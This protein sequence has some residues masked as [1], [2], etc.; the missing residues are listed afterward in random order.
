MGRAW[1]K[2]FFTLLLVSVLDTLSAFSEEVA[3]FYRYSSKDGLSCNY[4]HSITQDSHGFL[5]I[6]TEYGLNRFDGVHFRSF[7]AEDYPSLF[8]NQ[9]LTVKTGSDDK[10]LVASNNGLV[11]YYD[12]ENDTFGDLMPEDFN[13]TY[14]KSVTGFCT[15][16]RNRT[17]MTTS[18]GI[19]RFSPEEQKFA[20]V[21]LVTDSTAFTF[22]SKMVVDPFGRFLCG[23]YSGVV[24]IDSMGH[25][26][27][28]YDEL[29]KFNNMIFNLL[30]MD[31]YHYIVSSYV[32]SFWLIE[33]DEAGHISAP[34][35][36]E[37]PFR[38][39]TTIIKDSKDNYWFGTAGSG[40]WR[41]V[42]QNGRFS[43]ESIEPQNS[44]AE[45]LKKIHT[46]F[47][48]RDGDL[49]IGTQNAGL[50]RYSVARNSGSVHST[51]IGFP[52]VDGT[53]FA[54]DA[55]HNLL[56]GA[57]GHG[58]Y[59]LS[60]DFQIIK[61][62][63]MDDGLS[64]NNILSI[65]SDGHNN[66]WIAGWGGDVCRMNATTH[67][68]QQVKYD[69]KYP[70]KTAKSIMPC[71]NGEV[72]V[73]TAGDGVYTRSKEGSWTRKALIDST[74]ETKDVWMD[75]LCESSSGVKWIISS[76]TVWRDGDSLCVSVYPD[77]D[78]KKSH[79]PLLMHQ[80][81]C[82]E[83]G[84]LFVVSNKGVLRFSADGKRYD[85][86][87]FL[88]LGEYSSIVLDKNGT[89]WTGGSN[90]ILSFNEETRHYYKVLL[91][92]RF[93][94][95]NYFTVRAAYEDSLGRL[96][97]GS[98]EGFVMFD[99][100]KL[101]SSSGISYLSLSQLFVDGEIQQIG[102]DI[103]PKRLSDMSEL[104]LEHDETNIG[105]VVDVIDFSGLNDVE[106]SYH[107][108]GLD[109]SWIP[110]NEQRQVK[111]SHIPSGSYTLKVKAC[112]QG[113]EET[114]RMVSLPIRVYPPWW[115]SWWFISL[116]VFSALLISSLIIFYRFKRVLNQRE[117]LRKMVQERTKEL[118]A[119]NHL[120]EQK[121][122]VIEE[123]NQELENALTEK[124]RL[125]SVVAHD[126]KNPMFGIVGA[127]DSV[128]KKQ[129]SIENDR[130]ILKDI[131]LSAFNLQAAMVKLLEWARGKRDD[132][133]ARIQDESLKSSVNEVVILLQGLFKEK[134][135]HVSVDFHHTHLV[136]MDARMIGTAIRN[137]LSNAVKFTYEE[138]SIKISTSEENGKVVLQIVDDGVGMSA[139]R[140]KS[141]MSDDNVISTDGTKLERGTGLGFRMAR[142]YVEKC[143]G[144]MKV[145][146][147]ENKGTTIFIEL[148]CSL[149][150]EQEEVVPLD[151]DS[152]AENPSPIE[153]DELMSGNTV[154]IVDD[155]P[156]ILLHLR[157]I[158]EPCF[159]VIQAPNG[160]LGYDEIVNNHPDIILSD[161]EMPVCGGI[162][163]YERLKK[164]PETCYIPL[165]FLSAK[166]SEA[167]RLVGLYSGAIDYLSKP[168]YE[169]EL[170]AKLTNIL[171]LR[172]IRQQQILQE[173]MINEETPE[174]TN[175][176]LKEILSV[177]ENKFSDPDYSA[178]DIADELAMSRSTLSRKLK[179]ITDKTPSEL[180]SEYRLR[181]AQE[182]LKSGSKTV[183]EVAYAVGFNDPLYFSKK[184]KAYFGLNP[185]S[186]GTK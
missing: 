12:E 155:D 138:G 124:D 105:I 168:F 68:I 185:S 4:I 149:E 7:Y 64:C 118:D 130:K 170:L 74:F 171:T 34:K 181:K 102:S 137:V 103:L 78:K 19:Y 119:T 62:F 135:I 145:E 29:L 150:Q 106:L 90:G 48:D 123:R 1:L 79:A 165:L 58:I 57:D 13:D 128:L 146:S 86:L 89:F 35:E 49:W 30:K 167:D 76:R 154:M 77:Q 10:V 136:R 120:L 98:S 50:L 134:N 178:S 63:T 121:Q 14:F 36:V 75:G 81:V 16:N 164:N 18:N 67:E 139:D 112:R 43:F 125:L 111:I 153:N 172:R 3:T 54:E 141:I 15:D 156:L 159:R 107:I 73:T 23:N 5:W 99:P 163:M 113:S 131:Y 83:K 100:A 69:L 31:D 51:D 182:L 101:T 95:R 24:V 157:T 183:T 180:L 127:L 11:L 115:S 92:D 8:R 93:R 161:V 80:G 144:K 60:P 47:E 26:L 166:N 66:L 33:M 126:L 84:N 162:E 28:E 59:L 117:T 91:D 45:E 22:I 96:Y 151:E 110:L 169:R 160:S 87:D 132:L 85:W 116:L 129:N 177:I 148:Q 71:R 6:A 108:E 109:R 142:D 46:L 176:L 173:S 44:K 42:F 97:F 147:E 72:W 40:L 152:S 52:V 56:V 17:W 133:V 186:E 32:G 38:N 143:G 88:P 39:I 27:T 70:R 20:K 184:Y 94:S 175:P 140:L 9:L 82:D 21:P 37:A 61:H 25:H 104:Q 179:S 158:L 53:S 65:K 174:D 2:P 122:A 114:S 41:A 55:H